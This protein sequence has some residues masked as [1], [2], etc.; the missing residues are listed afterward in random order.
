M[1]KPYLPAFPTNDFLITKETLEVFEHT[2]ENLSLVKE[3]DV[4]Q[5]A[6]D[7]YVTEKEMFPIVEGSEDRLICGMKLGPYL[8]RSLKETYIFQKTLFSFK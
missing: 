3:I 8:N 6:V 7:Q 5:K 2:A 1:L 4:V